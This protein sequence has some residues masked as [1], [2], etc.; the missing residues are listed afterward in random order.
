VIPSI[1]IFGREGQGGTYLLRIHLREEA[2]LAFGRFQGGNLF[3]LSAGD[4]IYIGSA[5]NPHGATSLAP[6][7]LRHATRSEERSPQPIRAL[8]LQR[9]LELDLGSMKLRPP[10]AKTLHWHVDHLLDLE[11]A[12]LTGVFVIRG[13]IRLEA[14]IGHWLVI[15]PG[16]ELIVPGLGANDVA[17]GTHVLRVVG[18]ESWWDS[19]PDR[20]TVLL[21]AKG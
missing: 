11:E 9:F 18:G 5:L 19:L 3:T 12:D 17:G 21:A 15:D 8:M 13:P 16:T 7:L 2:K 20:I 1:H 4:Y 14:E 10:K 6:R